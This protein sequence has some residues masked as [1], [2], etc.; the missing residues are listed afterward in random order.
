MGKSSDWD[1]WRAPDQPDEPPPNPPSYNCRCWG[2]P[3]TPYP[4]YCDI[5]G[6]CSPTIRNNESIANPCAPELDGV[7]D[8]P[9]LE[10]R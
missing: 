3:R 8:G 10:F 6:A 2:P 4:S 7:C 9:A 1:F 5:I